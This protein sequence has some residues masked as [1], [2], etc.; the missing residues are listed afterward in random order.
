M[1]PKEETEICDWII[2]SGKNSNQAPLKAIGEE[3]VKVLKARFLF[4][5]AR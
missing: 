5:E 4:N 1:T 3:I 2:A